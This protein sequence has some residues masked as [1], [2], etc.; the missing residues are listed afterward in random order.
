MSDVKAFWWEREALEP[1]LREEGADSEENEGKR[2]MGI[3]SLLSVWPWE[4][5]KGA[6]SAENG[7][8]TKE[9]EEPRKMAE[10]GR[11]GTG[12]ESRADGEKRGGRRDKRKLKEK[13]KQGKRLTDLTG[14]G[15]RS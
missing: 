11:L 15:R 5:T 13:G 4:E 8:W 10:Q 6:E 9:E 1:H 2:G 14:N 12:E 3:F 7:R